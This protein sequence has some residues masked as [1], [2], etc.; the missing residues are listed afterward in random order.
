M[1]EKPFVSDDFAVPLGVET[2]DFIL[3]KLTTAVNHLDYEAVMSSKESLR[4]IFS[5]DDEWP[6]DGMTLEENYQDLLGH[7]EDFA[8]RRG[9]TYTVLS[10]A[11]DS[12]WGCVYI[13]R[14]QGEQ[15]D[16]QV[17]YWVRNLVKPMGL[18]EKLGNFLHQ[19]LAETWPFRA[20][21]FPGRKIAW[22]TWAALQPEAKTKNES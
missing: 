20:P 12:C 18:E 7:E 4:R 10:P 22:E 21:A 8:Q 15:Y 1:I 3:R 17:Y 13:Y 11:E 6:H 9:F 2:P 16:A 14:W 19:W 5:A